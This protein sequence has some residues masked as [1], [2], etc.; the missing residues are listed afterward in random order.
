MRLKKSSATSTAVL[1]VASCSSLAHA[2]ETDDGRKSRGS[3]GSTICSSP[4]FPEEEE[5]KDR[6]TCVGYDFSFFWK[7][8]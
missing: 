1:C 3:S 7:E 4:T 5:E 6:L 2:A 8:M